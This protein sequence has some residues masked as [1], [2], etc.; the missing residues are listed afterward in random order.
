MRAFLAVGAG[1]VLVA[2]WEV[3]DLATFLLMQRFYTLLRDE[4]TNFA[5]ALRHAQDWLCHATRSELASRLIELGVAQ[6]TPLPADNTAIPYAHPRFWAAF[7][8]IG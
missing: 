2:Q 4:P 6:Q 7:I 3:D 8:L 5:A 1:A